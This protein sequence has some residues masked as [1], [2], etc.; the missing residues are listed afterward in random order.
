MLELFKKR[1]GL[2]GTNMGAALRN[3]SDM[4]MDATFTNGTAYREV[5][6]DGKLI[7]AKY[8]AHTG[9]SIL[10]DNVDYYLQFRPKIHYPLGT[11]VDI[12]DDT[13]TYRTWLIV[14]R[15]NDNQ[16]VRYLVLECNFVFKW[17]YKD[18]IYS[19]LGCIRSRNSYNSGVWTSE[20][21]TSPENQIAAWFPTT[22]DIKT[23]NYDTRFLI[24]DNEINPVAYSVTK[25]EDMVP[26]GIT[27]LTLKQD[28][29][30]EHTDNP[31]LMIADYWKSSVLPE[32]KPSTPA[33]ENISWRVTYNGI[34]KDIKCGGSYKTFTA[35]LYDKDDN[36]LDSSPIWTVT[37]V[38]NS[39]FDIIQTGD[40]HILKMKALKYVELINSIVKIT[41]TDE[42]GEYSSSIELEVIP[43]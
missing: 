16:F 7:D 20:Y 41:V 8:S 39:K 30:N 25:R 43:L 22:Q 33:I 32:E 10:K 4:I 34:S 37:T 11:Y 27:K 9:Y 2:M 6:I 1:M 5:K 19:C 31:E 26:K 38:D 29:F 13:D 21:S 35:K 23:I 12:P 17:V 18:Y 24:T 3:Q 40:P 42:S 36:E 15:T 14:G 28:D